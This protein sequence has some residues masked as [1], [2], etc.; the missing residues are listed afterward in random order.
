MRNVSFFAGLS[1]KGLCQSNDTF[2]QYMLAKGNVFNVWDFEMLT[3]I[4]KMEW[5][6]QS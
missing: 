4:G 1:K 6:V 2:L 3:F 5:I